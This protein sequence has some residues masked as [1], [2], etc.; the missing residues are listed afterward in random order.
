MIQSALANQD[1]LFKPHLNEII[2]FAMNEG[3]LTVNIAHSGTVIGIFFDDIYVVDSVV[4]RFKHI[5]LLKIANI[6][7]GGFY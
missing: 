5:K 2:N 4:K 6:I 3:A 1:I 7:N